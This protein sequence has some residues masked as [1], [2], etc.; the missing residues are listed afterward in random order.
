MMMKETIHTFEKAGLG[1]AP[2]K[3]VGFEVKTYQ[4]SPESPVQVGDACRYCFTGIKDTFTIE[5]A[6]GK[7]FVVGS[8]CVNKTGDKGLIDVVKR[9]MNQL[10]AERT[11]ARNQ[12]KIDA[13]AEDLK[14][15]DVKK[16]LAAISH[17]QEWAAKQGMT[18]L[19]WAEWMMKN[20]GQSGMMRVVRYIA[21]I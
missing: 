18:A 9:Q 20:A 17:P 11:R 15:E 8:T 7:R 21:K 19:D 16:K 4:A 10:K 13:A 12:E 3:V 5:S 2:F 14:K 1:K 6:D